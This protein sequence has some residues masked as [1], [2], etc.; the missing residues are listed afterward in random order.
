MPETRVMN[1]AKA[2][3]EKAAST[4]IL[5]DGFALILPMVG[6]PIWEM[7]KVSEYDKDTG[8]P[9]KLIWEP[10]RR[11]D[12]K[13]W[14]DPHLMAF[15]CLS[16]SDSLRSAILATLKSGD[17]GLFTLGNQDFSVEFIPDRNEGSLQYGGTVP[18][19]LQ[20]KKMKRL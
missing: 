3:F 6:E 10:D 7:E 4:S 14:L 17:M 11:W 2:M 18:R 16:K 8:R 15:P 19:H 20:F 1:T 13:L 9:V 12:G 5:K